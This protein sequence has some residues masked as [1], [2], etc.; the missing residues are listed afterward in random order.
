YNST[1]NDG[2]YG[3]APPALGYDFF[4]GP[5]VG[6][7]RLPLSSFNKYINGT[8]PQN[9]TQTYN[10]M[11]GLYPDGSVVIDPFGVETKINVAGDPVS[12]GPGSWLDS[13]PADRRFLM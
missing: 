8:D 12:P 13:A 4:Q 6:V 7:D 9:A 5:L 11:K 1:N 2:G 10:Y 3:S